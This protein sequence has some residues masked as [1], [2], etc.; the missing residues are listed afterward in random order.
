MGAAV[1]AENITQIG[2]ICVNFGVKYVFISSIFITESIKLS[3]IIRKKNHAL[4]VLCSLHN[5][6][7]V[8]NENIT[9]NYLF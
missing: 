6:Q 2:R 8:L 1:E 5:F 9:R 7:F 3:S 4:C